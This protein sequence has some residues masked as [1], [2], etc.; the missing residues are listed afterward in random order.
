MLFPLGGGD[1]R[2]PPLGGGDESIP[3]PPAG[4]GWG[5]GVSQSHRLFDIDIKLS[6]EGWPAIS[7]QRVGIG[8]E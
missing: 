3:P 4:A 2:M 6:G 1:E 5:G 8:R 7:Y